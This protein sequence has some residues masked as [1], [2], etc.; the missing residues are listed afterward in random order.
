[1]FT[2][3]SQ[4]DKIPASESGVFSIGG[5]LDHPRLWGPRPHQTP[6]LYLAVTTLEQQGKVVD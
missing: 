4:S 3:P 1:M 6:H 2:F 5:T